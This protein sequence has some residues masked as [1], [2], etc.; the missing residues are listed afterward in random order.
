MMAII[1]AK[2]DGLER[3]LGATLH[4]PMV[5]DGA[6]LEGVVQRGLDEL[7]AFLVGCGVK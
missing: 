5:A 4:S 3:W 1:Q 6:N 2:Q 7:E